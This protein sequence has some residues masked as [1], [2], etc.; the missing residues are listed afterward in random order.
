MRGAHGSAPE[1]AAPALEQPAASAAASSHEGPRRPPKID[2]DIDDSIEVKHVQDLLPKNGKYKI[3]KDKTLHMR[4][5]IKWADVDGRVHHFSRGW[6]PR[7]A[8]IVRSFTEV[9]ASRGLDG[10]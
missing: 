6:G 5:E 8:S 4:W 3:S 9:C 2:Y 10:P 7:S 1:S